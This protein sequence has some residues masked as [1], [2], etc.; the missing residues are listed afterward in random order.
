MMKIRT[1]LATARA[2]AVAALLATSTLAA[3]TATY[4]APD[5]DVS[6]HGTR[7]DK[8]A[9]RSGGSPI[10]IRGG[11]SG[12]YLD[13]LLA[14]INARRSMVGTPPIMY[15]APDANDAVSSYL[16]DLT[17]QMQ[18]YRACFHGQNNP[19]APAWD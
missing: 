11:S 9:P 3:P 14:E 15:I 8:K 12:P 19:V 4:A 1:T 2:L 6:F 17:P 7:P 10:E 16:A 5:T 13:Q 18:A